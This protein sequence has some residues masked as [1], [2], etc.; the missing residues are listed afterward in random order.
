MGRRRRNRT[1]G[2][3]RDERHFRHPIR[4]RSTDDQ[5]GG[6]QRVDVSIA[7]QFVLDVLGAAHHFSIQRSGECAKHRNADRHY[8]N[9][10]SQLDEF[11]HCWFD[12]AHDIEHPGVSRRHNHQCVLQMKKL[13]VALLLFF[14]L[15]ASAQF[16]GCTLGFCAPKAAAVV[17]NVW[18]P[19]ASDTSLVFTNTIPAP[20]TVTSGNPSTGFYGAKSTLSRA[21]GKCYF[22]LQINLSNT[23]LAFVGIGNAAAPTAG[24]FVGSDANGFGWSGSGQTFTGGSGFNTIQTFTTADYTAIAF[25][26]TAKKIWFQTITAGVGS[27]WNNSPTDNP[28][29]GTGGIDLGVSGANINAGPYYIMASLRAVTDQMTLNPGSSAFVGIVPSGY[30]GC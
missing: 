7:L 23:S 11:F 26:I 17:N 6:R 14:P 4:C 29:T 24:V 10:S 18:D 30:T 9:V 16:N 12:R 13:L 2:V 15:T 20:L 25:D 22:Q 28:A 21:S 27:N 8:A 5:Y 19:A 3:Q 1:C